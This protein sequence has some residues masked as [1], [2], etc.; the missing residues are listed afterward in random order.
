MGFPPATKDE[1]SKLQTLCRT[2]LSTSPHHPDKVW[3]AAGDYHY[4]I[5]Y[6]G[7][8][9]GCS[10]G[11]ICTNVADL[12]MRNDSV[13]LVQEIQLDERTV[14]TLVAL[15]LELLGPLKALGA[16]ATE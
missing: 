7:S 6:V 16:Q 15:G 10:A 9:A 8:S 5:C 2:A 14:E 12:R 3:E 1:M 13:N 11:V 4:A